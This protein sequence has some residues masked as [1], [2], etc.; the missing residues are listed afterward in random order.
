MGEAT[1]LRESSWC[2]VSDIA[3]YQMSVDR[4]GMSAGVHFVPEE[5]ADMSDQQSVK[6]QLIIHF[7]QKT[8]GH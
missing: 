6:L 8:Y 5:N 2:N 7:I 1:F 3:R 4:Q